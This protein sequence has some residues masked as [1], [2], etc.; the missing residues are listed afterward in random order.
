MTV[1]MNRLANALGWSEETLAVAVA[2]RRRDAEAVGI[3]ATVL[4]PHLAVAAANYRREGQRLEDAILK[5][6]AEHRLS[7]REARPVVG[8]E[9]R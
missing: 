1:R 2:A 9:T 6:S 3:R 5:A 4:K 8:E 7:A